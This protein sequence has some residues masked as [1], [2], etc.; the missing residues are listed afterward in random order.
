MPRTPKPLDELSRTGVRYRTDEKCAEKMRERSKKLLLEKRSERL[1]E[2]RNFTDERE[3]KG[4]N[5]R[6][7]NGVKVFHSTA[8]C[9]FT[10][11]ARMS[12]WNWDQAGILPAA[13][14]VDS[15]KRNWYSWEYVESLRRVLEVRLRS[16]LDEFG[17]MLRE[18]FI[19]DGII[20][21]DGNNAEVS[22]SNAE[23]S[24]SLSPSGKQRT[25][26]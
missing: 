12:I 17:T 23:M 18:Q 6:I 26:N 2:I 16:S 4:W 8:L 14:M 20:D 7:F 1:K 10:G 21:E 3:G 9:E 5:P 15:R 25:T 13:T 22:V 11:V 24:A 19:A